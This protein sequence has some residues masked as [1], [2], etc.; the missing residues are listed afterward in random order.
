MLSLTFL[1]ILAGCKAPP[2]T[3]GF[4]S[5]GFSFDFS[6]KLSET[7]FKGT[8]QKD[9]GGGYE[10]TFKEPS[11]VQKISFV[12]LLGNMTVIYKD[13]DRFEAGRP[14]ENSVVGILCL[15]FEKAEKSGNLSGENYKITMKNEIPIKLLSNGVSVEIKNFAKK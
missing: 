9:A 5:G 3:K 12:Y 15:P 7:E 6:F 10:I 13:L 4:L 11:S 1:I 8:L 2:E 14:P